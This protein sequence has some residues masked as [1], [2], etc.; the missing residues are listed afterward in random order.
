VARTPPPYPW[1]DTDPTVRSLIADNFVVVQRDMLASARRRDPF[2]LDLAREWHTRSLKGVSLGEPGIGGKFRGEGAQGGRLRTYRVTVPPFEGVPP[3]D[4]AQALNDFA[5]DLG[6][7]IETLDDKWPPSELVDQE[8][9]LA[10][11]DACVRAH[12][13]WVRIHPFPDSNGTTA[14]LW[15]NWIAVRYGLPAFVR[16]KPRPDASSGYWTA[17]EMSMRGNH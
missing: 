16:V 15:A 14:R 12:G 11:V 2:S 8:G 9:Q 7:L 1:D 3:Q 5:G 10:V 17:G 4:V 6:P 13:E